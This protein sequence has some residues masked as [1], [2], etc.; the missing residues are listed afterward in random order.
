MGRFASVT[1]SAVKSLDASA[2]SLD[3]SAKYFG[4]VGGVLVAL[5]AYYIVTIYNKQKLFKRRTCGMGNLGNFKS[6]HPGI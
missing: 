4:L 3:A 2:K 1:T 6:L 5:A